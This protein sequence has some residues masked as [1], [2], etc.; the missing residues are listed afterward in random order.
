[1]MHAG[2]CG[3]SAFDLKNGQNQISTSMTLQ[4]NQAIGHPPC[5][6]SLVQNAFTGD[7]KYLGLVARKHVFGVSVKV[8]FK[9]VSSATE[10]S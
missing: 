10:T 2:G 3:V 9:P 7:L 8:S 1:M 5:R 6:H 4:L